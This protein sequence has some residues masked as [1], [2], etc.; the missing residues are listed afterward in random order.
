MLN[1]PIFI[2]ISAWVESNSHNSELY[3][4]SQA[5]HIFLAAI[6]AI[7]PQYTMYLKGGLLMG[8]VYNSPRRTMD[9][10]LTAGFEPSKGIDSKIKDKLNNIFPGVVANL[11][12]I[13]CRFVIEEIN[14]N[15][16]K[17]EGRILDNPLEEASWPSLKFVNKF[18]TK[19]NGPQVKIEIDLS[20]N[21]KEPRYIDI[22]NIGDNIEI[23][24]YSLIDLISEKYR[25]ILQRTIRR[26]RR[27]QDVFD[28]NFL[29]ER[30]DFDNNQKGEILNTFVS[31]CE[32]RNIVPNKDSLE[33]TD[34]IERAGFEWDNIELE[35]GNLPEFNHCYKRVNRFYKS[36][37]WKE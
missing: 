16:K 30:Y 31:K 18:T 34:I 23:P 32:T 24:S 22:I 7:H 13:G 20:F 9:I 2:D 1:S 4:H 26:R 35:I 27:H 21:E 33:D 29:L 14:I 5:T 3:S 11:G 36:L 19:R 8:L 15:P 12:Y 37:P 17:I 6:A 10:D 25:A 28:L